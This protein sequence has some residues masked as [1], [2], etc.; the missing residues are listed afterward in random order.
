MMVAQE[1]MVIAVRETAI[2]V[3]IIAVT[4]CMA[5]SDSVSSSVTRG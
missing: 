4:D 2:V 5:L 1:A 3:V